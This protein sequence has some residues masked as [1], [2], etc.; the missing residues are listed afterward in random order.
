MKAPGE[1]L[2]P[3]EEHLAKDLASGAGLV[4]R[5]VRLTE[6]IRHRMEEIRESRTRIVAASDAERRRLER[7]IHDG[8]QQ[9]LVALAVKVRLARG[10][11]GRDPMKAGQ[12]LEQTEAEVGQA[13]EDLRDLARGIY[14]PLLADQGLV[15][16]LESQARRAPLPVRVEVEGIGRYS[17]EH[18]AA[19][20]FCVLEALQNVAKYAAA[21]KAIVRLTESDGVL[22]FEVEDD[23]A[24]FDPSARGY[25]TGMQGMADR[26]SALGGEL[27]VRS[28][29]GAGTRVT[30]RVPVPVR[31]LVG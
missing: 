31:E 29:P 13:L 14:P 17:Q 18:E 25:G 2:T 12:L 7:N 3:A 30:G 5:N 11:A 21:S 1:R 6:E 22:T 27:R 19:A 28:A 24:G 9:Q 10:L 26:L 23:G 20:Y 15:A 8:A 4:L 16:A